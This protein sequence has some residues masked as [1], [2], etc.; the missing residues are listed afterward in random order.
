MGTTFIQEDKAKGEGENVPHLTSPKKVTT[1]KTNN[2]QTTT[3]QQTI[4]I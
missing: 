1:K 3:Q 4:I 2:P